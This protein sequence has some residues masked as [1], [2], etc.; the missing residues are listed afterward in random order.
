MLNW[1]LGKPAEQNRVSQDENT[2][3]LEPPETPAPVFAARA[4]KSAIFG[5]PARPDDTICDN[6]E[7]EQEIAKYN[8]TLQARSMSPTKPAGILLT[9]GTATMRRKTVSFDHEV[10][11]NEKEQ[12]TVIKPKS[13]SGLPDDFPGKFPSPWVSKAGEVGKLKRKTSL[14]KTLEEARGIKTERGRPESRTESRVESRG[15]SSKSESSRRASSESPRAIKPE[16]KPEPASNTTTKRPTKPEKSNQDIL[17]EL[18]PGNKLDPDMTM[19]LNEPKSQSGRF[20][21]TEYETYHTEALAEMRK[22]IQYKALAKSYA[23]AKDAEAVDLAAKLR[24]EQRKVLEMESQ[25]SRI[26]ARISQSGRDGKD[27]ESPALIKELARQTA[28]AVQ[29]KGHMEEFRVALE[30]NGI[31]VSPIKGDGDRKRFSTEQTI[32]DAHHELKKA[33]DQLREMFD[34]R[35]EV[36]KLRQTVS[37]AEKKST[38]LEAE[39]NKLTQEL[40]HADLRLEKH[41]EKCDKKRRQSD[42]HKQK[43]EEALQNLQR[44]YDQLKEQAKASRR[45]AEQ[46]LKKRH[47]QVIDL[48]KEIASIRG[49]DSTVQEFQQALHK[50]DLEHEKVVEEYKKQIEDLKKGQRKSPNAEMVSNNKKDKKEN[51]LLPQD[52]PLPS[53]EWYSPKVSPVRESHIPVASP[54]ISRPV[55]AFSAKLPLTE[56]SHRTPRKRA[57]QPALS[58]IINNATVDTLPPQRYG[59][60]QH[61]PMVNMTPLADRFSLLSMKE[62]DMELPSFEAPLPPE[63]VRGVQGIHARNCHASPRP[64]MFNIASSPPK[65]ALM[66]AHTSNDLSRQRSNNDLGPRRPANASVPTSRMS[67]QEP[68]KARAPLPPERAA[69]AK[70]RLEEKRAERAKARASSAGKENVKA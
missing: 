46:L 29:Y 25:I 43:R 21:K 59:P 16:P 49:S 31:K 40:L 7:D 62:P 70:A 22:L 6:E 33:R 24:E 64:S 60:V 35:E 17:Q 18:A 65:A 5:T 2:E 48:K 12:A 23:Q 30:E 51:V 8:G 28:L 10:V 9:P 34:L 52:V 13:K 4:L 68:S 38:K 57:S 3:L 39:N 14:T 54:A 56:E 32:L 19:D 55:K 45:E 50:K 27:D 42:E 20:W 53:T 44:D 58:E 47:D 37:D 36:Q 11:D 61:T 69:A 26:S 41:L 15:E 67:S 66:R 63:P 1:W